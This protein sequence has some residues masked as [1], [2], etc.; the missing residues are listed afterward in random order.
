MKPFL[1][2][3]L[4]SNTS[5]IFLL[6]VLFLTTPNSSQ[7]ACGFYN[8][9]N[10]T[11]GVEGEWYI[12]NQVGSSPT[13]C[14]TQ[15]ECVPSYGCGSLSSNGQTCSIGAGN[16]ASFSTCQELTN[17]CCFDNNSCTSVTNRL[18]A[19]EPDGPVD[20]TSEDDSTGGGLT[21]LAG[22]SNE[23]FNLLNPLVQFGDAGLN[24]QLSTPG[25][26]VS[27]ILAFSLPLAGLILFVMLVWG[28]FEILAGSPTSKSVDA[29]KQR[30]TAAIVGF[31]LLFT[32]YW[33]VQ[34]LEVVFGVAIF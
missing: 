6:L 29:G 27:R 9:Q 13:C 12:C 7:A 19:A 18:L 30:I 2:K 22:P 1:L 33:L 14:N 21:I 4:I 17:I 34:I 20:P 25:G 5:I 15:L 8:A 23:T 10:Q 32:S 26:I 24:T 28:G 3:K 16:T 31:I 11:C